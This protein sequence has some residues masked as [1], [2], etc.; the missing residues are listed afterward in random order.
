MQFIKTMYTYDLKR[1]ATHL[2][3]SIILVLLIN[4][5]A[6]ADYVNKHWNTVTATVFIY[7]CHH[8]CE[9]LP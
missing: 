1:F 3:V 7:S 4:T 5:I 2:Q 9:I 6:S 8:V